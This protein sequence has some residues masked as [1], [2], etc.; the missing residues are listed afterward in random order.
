MLISGFDVFI[1]LEPT[2]VMDWDRKKVAAA[3]G[4]VALISVWLFVPILIQRWYGYPAI[5][6]AFVI[7][8]VYFLGFQFWKRVLN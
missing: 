8:V 6:I 2:L 4:S 3:V 5:P 1:I 7:I